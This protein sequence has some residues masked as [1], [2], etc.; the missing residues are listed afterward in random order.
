MNC[1]AIIIS[2]AQKKTSQKNAEERERERGTLQTKE[3][4]REKKRKRER[5]TLQTNEEA[6]EKK[7]KRERGRKREREKEIEIQG[8]R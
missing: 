3:E 4:A 2:K 1:D 8:V 5:G 6:R 7:R